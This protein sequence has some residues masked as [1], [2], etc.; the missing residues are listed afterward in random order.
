MLTRAE[1]F[2]VKEIKENSR[3][4]HECERSALAVV[5]R[6]PSPTAELEDNCAVSHKPV[7]WPIGSSIVAITA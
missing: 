4:H 1:R 7:A 5:V 2:E 3:L 6:R